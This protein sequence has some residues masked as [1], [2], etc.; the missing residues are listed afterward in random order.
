MN[1]SD[2]QTEI[3]HSIDMYKQTMEVDVVYRKEP[4]LGQQIPYDCFVHS[5]GGGFCAIEAKMNKSVRGGFCFP[6]FFKDRAHQPIK[7]LEAYKSGG[8]GF[9][10]VKWCPPQGKSRVFALSIESFFSHREAT[11]PL[12]WVEERALEVLRIPDTRGWKGRQWDLS[13]LFQK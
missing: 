2:F 7:L 6:S 5:K 11:V 12:V 13:F 9:L 1:E 4:D 10:I 8:R 3:K